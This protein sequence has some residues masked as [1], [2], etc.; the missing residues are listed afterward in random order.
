ML[1]TFGGPGALG[2]P[3]GSMALTTGSVL[4]DFRAQLGVKK[5]ASQGP[6]LLKSW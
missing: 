2:K 4:T 6:C 3:A 1:L 5:R